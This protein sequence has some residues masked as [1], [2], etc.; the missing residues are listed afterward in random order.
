MNSYFAFKR[1]LE[2]N[3]GQANVVGDA[4][5]K[6]DNLVMKD[7]HR[8]PRYTVEFNQLA[9]L[10]QWGDRALAHRFYS[11]LPDRIKDD[12]ARIPGGRPHALHLLR[13]SVQDSDNRYWERKAERDRDHR[14]VQD[15][16]AS[17]S[18]GGKK[19]KDS[20]SDTKVSS[21]GSTSK[22]TSVAVTVKTPSASTSDRQKDYK[23]KLGA[24]GKLN[25]TERQRWIDGKL[26][27]F[28]GKAGHIAADCRKKQASSNARATAL[29]ETPTAP[30][31]PTTSEASGK[32]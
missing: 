7:S 23:D 26:C 9:V 3:F 12:L 4:E 22:S 29:E 1:E 8:I 6:L 17:T 32:A 5:T 15:K 13:V 31:A 28:C 2:Y 18:G 25:A 24:D 16:S 14:F 30:I 11:G 27:M 19:T 10:C 20:K 21:S